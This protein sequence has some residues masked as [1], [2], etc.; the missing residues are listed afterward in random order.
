MMAVFE[1]AD[2]G[3][4]STLVG[5]LARG[6]GG[7]AVTGVVVAPLFIG[8]LLGYVVTERL[9][10]PEAMAIEANLPEPGLEAVRR[11]PASVDG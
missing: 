7:F 6:A 3:G 2:G 9:D 10:D 8:A 11:M 4:G 5:A 1:Q